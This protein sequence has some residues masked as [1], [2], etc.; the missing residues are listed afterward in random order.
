[1][2]DSGDAWTCV[3]ALKVLIIEDDEETAEALREALN[4]SG[5]R[6]A[7]AL[8]GAAGMRLKNSHPAN[9]PLSGLI[10]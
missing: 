4:R 1:M 9:P 2:S 10:P 8:S 7:C 3:A 6:T 5:M